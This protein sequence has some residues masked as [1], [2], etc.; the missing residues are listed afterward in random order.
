MRLLIVTGLPASGKTTLA[1]ELALR[2][3]AA[4]LRKDAIKEPLLDALGAGDAQHSRRL[5]DISFAALFAL[6]RE[7][8]TAGV[9]LILEGNFRP[10]EHEEVL[11]GLAPPRTAQI[12][13]RIEEPERQMRL[14][15]RQD[16][17]S[18]HPG[19]RD[20]LRRDDDLSADRFLDLPGERFLFESAHGLLQIDGWWHGGR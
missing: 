5:S 17:P 16:D 13:C 3:G 18:R 6:V 1:R 8:A 2:Y 11:R 20:A 7:L 14:A 9:D 12:L 4:L 10:G 15:A 19:H